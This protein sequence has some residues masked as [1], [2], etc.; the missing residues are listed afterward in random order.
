MIKD[1]AKG[2][3][4]CGLAPASFTAPNDAA[5]A[6]TSIAGSRFQFFADQRDSPTIRISFSVNSMLHFR[7]FEW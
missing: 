6:Q 5:V 2:R 4:L 7:P 1:S 3:G